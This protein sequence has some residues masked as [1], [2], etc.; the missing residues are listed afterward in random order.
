MTTEYTPK[1]PPFTYGGVENPALDHAGVVVIPIPYDSTASYRQGSRMGPESIIDASRYM[2]LFDI[3]TGWSPVEIGIHTLSGVEPSRGSPEE[4]ISRI[5][6]TV[7]EVLSL[8]KFPVLLGGEHTVSLGG[9]QAAGEFAEKLG[10][11]VLDAHCDLRDEYEGTKFSHACTNR[12]ISEIADSLVVAGTRSC[13]E[14][15]GELIQNEKL[16]FF[17]W[18]EGNR[19]KGLENLQRALDFITDIGGT[20]YLS[21][22]L[23]VF[24]PAEMPGVSTPEPSG[25]LYDEV[26]PFLRELARG[27]NLIGMDVVE[28]TPIEGDVRSQFMASKLVY[29]VLAYAFGCRDRSPT[30]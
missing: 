13:S 15:E 1:W 3:E 14:E 4:T 28:L 26:L 19:E 21:I 11:V 12:R 20:W 16:D 18:T 25:P 6:R 30:C 2:E 27:V 10:V 22:D 5:R 8:S 17:H 23:D 9:V 29:K 24:S 7:G